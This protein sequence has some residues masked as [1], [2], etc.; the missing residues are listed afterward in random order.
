MR[1]LEAVQPVTTD[2]PHN[3]ERWDD[4]STTKAP[5]MGV[6][7][8]QTDDQQSTI[9]EKEQGDRGTGEGC[10][11]TEISPIVVGQPIDGRNGT[12]I[13]G[14]IHTL[15]WQHQVPDTPDS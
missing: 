11:S 9:V 4:N 14:C 12:G 13:V 2:T 15:R 6:Q 1:E 8:T 5:A 3:T 7:G 10:G